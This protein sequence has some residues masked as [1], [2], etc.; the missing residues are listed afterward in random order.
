[1][2]KSGYIQRYLQIIRIVRSNRYISLEDLI[3][4]VEEGLSYYDDTD[5]VGV[6]RRTILRDIG[7][8]RSGMG[9]SI[10]Y[11]RRHKGYFI[12]EDEDQT[13]DI[14]RILAQYD[15]MTTM[16]A[17][18]ELSSF[19]FPERRK[20]RGTEHLNPLIHAVRRS[21]MVG[22]LYVKFDNS[23]S[24]VRRVMPYALK[25][26]HGR[27]YLLAIEDGENVRR[28]GEIKSWGL[29]RIRELTVTERRFV[30][31]KS[32]DPQSEFRDSFGVS[33]GRE[34]PVEEVIL[35]FSPKS[36]RYNEAFPLHESQETLVDDGKEFRIRLRLK[37]TMDFVQELLSQSEDL[38]VI[39]PKHL[40]K[41]I[42]DI[43]RKA[44]KRMG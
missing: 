5:S 18:E 43:C 24:R 16:R 38:E 35:S 13:A 7:E 34:L 3:R 23:A 39:A 21:L 37:I 27:W 1:M 28:P 26:S 29:D 10:D 32:L 12:P 9:I 19:V 2:S 25:E 11:S 41:Q 42:R 40:R 36:G 44:A 20:A 22:F 15:L 8:I 4:K 31:D 17:R 6:S 30:R 33:F 14:E